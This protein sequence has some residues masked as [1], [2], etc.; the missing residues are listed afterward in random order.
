MSNKLYFFLLLILFSILSEMSSAEEE[1]FTT[2][3]YIIFKL[4]PWT[5]FEV[6]KKKYETFKEKAIASNR[7]HTQKYKLMR[8]AYDKIYEEYKNNNYKDETFFSILIKTI[9][10]IFTYEFIVLLLLFVTCFV[11]KFNTYSAYL[12]GAFV[13]IDNIIPHWF[14]TMLTQYI[15]SFILG[16]VLYF[17]SYFCSFICGKKN[18]QKGNN[19]DSNQNI[20]NNSGYK[21]TRKRF[22]KIEI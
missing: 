1:E 18:K 10:N 21:L 11:Y 22:E 20:S 17:R 12:V 4:P 19:K 5:K 13:A 3:P 8:K 14:G 2:N 16:T 9:K 15:V 6:I 7:T